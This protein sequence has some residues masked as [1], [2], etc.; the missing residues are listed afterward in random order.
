MKVSQT[1]VRSAAGLT[2]QLATAAW[3]QVPAAES[4][5]GLIAR[6]SRAMPRFRKIVR[7]AG[8]ML[9]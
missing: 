8:E 5:L 2:L 7:K 3:L 6:M 1:L 9:C 4:V